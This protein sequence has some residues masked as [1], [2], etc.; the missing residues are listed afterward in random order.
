MNKSHQ[1]AFQFL[2]LRP[3]YWRTWALIVCCAVLSIF[4]AWLRAKLGDT[5]APILLWRNA[6]QK[7]I[8]LTNISLCY[9]KL[10]EL[11]KHELL[12][13]NARIF[14]HLV[15]GYG[16]L[17]FRS[18]HSLR[19]Q[20]DIDGLNIVQKAVAEGNNIILL[21]PHAMAM[22]YAGQCLSTEHDITGVV[23]LHNDNPLMDWIVTRLRSRYEGTVFSKDADMLP[24]IRAVRAGSWFYY[25]PDED[26]G[27]QNF[28]FV[29]FFGVPKATQP[30]LGRLAKACNA[31]VIPTMSAYS[32]TMRRFS[33]KFF[34]PIEKFPSRDAQHDV[35]KMNKAIENIVDHDPAQYMW[36]NKIFRTRPEGEPEFY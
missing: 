16:Q 10:T 1:P 26:R 31:A 13:K 15:L 21:T 22:E 7:R 3:K 5:I 23:R 17:L 20:F 24:L 11:E 25:L 6:K 28:I 4:S 35:E 30:S 18:S 27:E 8:A 19:K 36:T 2:F 32:P 9:P 33:I 34:A 12:R 29:P 14:T